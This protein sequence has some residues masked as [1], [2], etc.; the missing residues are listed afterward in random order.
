MLY[1]WIIPL[2]NIM[3]S[4][5]AGIQQQLESRAAKEVFN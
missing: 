1:L 5:I 2:E 3:W 4:P